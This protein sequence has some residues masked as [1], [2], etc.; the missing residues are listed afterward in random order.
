M[1]SAQSTRKNVP[2]GL[3]LTA[4]GNREATLMGYKRDTNMMVSTTIASTQ[5]KF[6]PARFTN[7]R[8][9]VRF[10]L[11]P[12]NTRAFH[13]CRF[14]HFG[15]TPMQP[16]MRGF[17]YAV[18]SRRRAGF[19]LTRDLSMAKHLYIDPAFPVKP[20]LLNVRLE[21]VFQ[22]ELDHARIH[23]GGRDL[24]EG[25]RPDVG[26][27]IRGR[28][29]VI[30]IGELRMVEGIE[31]F[32]TE[33]DCMVLYDSDPFQN[34]NIPVELPGA[35][36]NADSRIA[37]PRS[38]SDSGRRAKRSLVEVARAATGAAQPLFGVTRCG[39]VFVSHPWT[40]LGAAES[41]E[42]AARRS[43]DRS[44]LGI[45]NRHGSAVLHDGNS[46]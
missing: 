44:G 35:I 40:Q 3:W 18:V 11:R 33:L 43:I 16:R 27:G 42:G 2:S 21:A 13:V 37:I 12:R 1:F 32:G 28:R 9:K 17:G 4:A 26:K 34:G 10:P 41:A 15:Q 45:R 14:G 46:G 22:C 6:L 7:G 29:A 25:A 5:L 39:D 20:G 36:N 30:R 8:V 38:I 24:S 31:E 19:V 23:V